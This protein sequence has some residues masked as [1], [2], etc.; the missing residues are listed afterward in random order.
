LHKSATGKNIRLKWSHE[1]FW[2]SSS[3]IEKPFTWFNQVVRLSFD[4]LLWYTR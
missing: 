1:S 4:L 2:E 3:K